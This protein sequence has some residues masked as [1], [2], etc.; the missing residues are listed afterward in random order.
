MALLLSETARPARDCEGLRLGELV[1]NGESVDMNDFYLH[2]TMAQLQMALLGNSTEA[3][4][5]IRYIV[6]SMYH[7]FW[8]NGRA[9]IFGTYYVP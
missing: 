1:E 7:N 4:I 6:H 8:Y 5:I 9:L 3:G 2:E